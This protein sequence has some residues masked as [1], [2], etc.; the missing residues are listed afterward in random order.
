MPGKNISPATFELLGTVICLS[1]FSIQCPD[2]RIF[3]YFCNVCHTLSTVLRNAYSTKIFSMFDVIVHVPQKLRVTQ[4]CKITHTAVITIDKQECINFL[5]TAISNTVFMRCVK[6]SD[7]ALN[8][9]SR[10]WSRN[11]NRL[12]YRWLQYKL[13]RSISSSSRRPQPRGV[14]KIIIKKPV[15]RNKWVGWDSPFGKATRHGLDGPSIK[16]RWGEIFRTRQTGPA[17]HPAT[18]TMGTGSFPGVKQPRRG[19]DHPPPFCA[20]VKEGLELYIYSS[21]RS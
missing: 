8:I 2:Q 16:S 10:I 14:G 4:I 11:I 17:A 5:V 3:K 9:W 13:H 1:Q 21:G 19:A 20:K 18:C 6:T 7:K 12:I 15:L